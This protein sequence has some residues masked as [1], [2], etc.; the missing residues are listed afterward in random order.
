MTLRVVGAGVGRTGTASLKQALE[1]L[2]G[3]TCHHMFEV[4]ANQDEIPVWKAA[5]HGTMPDWH[6]FLSRYVA[7]VDWPGAAFWRELTTAYPD[8]LVLLS[9]REP[10]SWYKSASETIFADDAGGDSPALLDMWHALARNRFC[11]DP[12][13]KDKL[14][15]AML[16]H[17]AAVEAAIPPERL[18]QWQA[19]D[20]WEPI[21]TALDLPVPDEP[22][23]HTNTKAQFLAS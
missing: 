11:D 17:N 13:D 1:R 21:C 23:P 2:L 12:H 18:L 19:G 5:A 9:V 10:E 14:I 15:A 7:I 16:A 6:A 3:G 20:G 22:F 8:A 4:S